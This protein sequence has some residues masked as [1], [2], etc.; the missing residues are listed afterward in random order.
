[1]YS[2]THSKPH[3]ESHL[4]NRRNW[5]RA[6]VL[7]ANDGILS[8]A[9]LITGMAAGDTSH[10]VILLAGLAGLVAGATS[11]ATG[12]YVSVSSQSDIERADLGIEKRELAR[13]PKFEMEELAQIYVE[14]GLELP[15]AREVAKKL[16]EKDALGTHAR[17]E[18]GISEMTKAY[19]FQ[20]ALASA[21]SFCAGGVLPLVTAAL[22]P[23]QWEILCVTGATLFSLVLLGIIGAKTSGT[24]ILRPTLR[25]FLWG[26]LSLGATAVI[27]NMFG[28]KP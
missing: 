26:V 8:I 27:G 18:L 3:H 17:E 10:D 21:A 6:A 13:N 28:I 15:L 5:L 25:V 23:V 1:M 7:G 4:V 22:V 11:M 24:K 12:E 14:R 2:T 16:M 19:P 9:S 20:A